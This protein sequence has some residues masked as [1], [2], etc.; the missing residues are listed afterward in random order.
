MENAT[1]ERT[2]QDS[3][4]VSKAILFEQFVKQYNDLAAF[5]N[6]LPVN[7]H[8][9]YIAIQHLDN[10]YLW[11]KE[12]FNTFGFIQQQPQIVPINEEVSPV[13][14]VET[15]QAETVY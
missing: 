13:A 6:R 8:I 12:S 3:L 7:P 5:V 9:K 11:V 1:Q 4:E 14:E 2:A 15:A 10:G